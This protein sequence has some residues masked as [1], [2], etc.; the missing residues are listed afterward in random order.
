MTSSR[1]WCIRHR[2]GWC[3]TATGKPSKDGSDNVAT[4][5]QHFVIMP[6]GCKVCKPDCPECLRILAKRA[7]KESR[8]ANT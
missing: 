7:K 1:V 8:E 2:E 4:V 3:A 6:G 5:C